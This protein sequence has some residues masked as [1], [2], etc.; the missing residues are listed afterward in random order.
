MRVYT[1]VWILDEHVCHFYLHAYSLRSFSMQ[2]RLSEI[3]LT[4]HF[5]SHGKHVGHETIQKNSPIHRRR[6]M[7]SL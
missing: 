5:V 7:K 4:F 6:V 2:V 1:Y 3:A